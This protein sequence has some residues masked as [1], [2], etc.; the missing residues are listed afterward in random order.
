MRD[1]AHLGV[2]EP[3]LVGW[4]PLEARPD[5]HRDELGHLLLDAVHR[6]GR[7]GQQGRHAVEGALQQLQHRAVAGVER[8]HRDVR[9]GPRR[10]VGDPR[11]HRHRAH[12]GPVD[13]DRFARRTG[14][15]RVSRCVA[16]PEQQLLE[17]EVVRDLVL[18]G[19]EHV[20]VAV[21]DRRVVQALTLL[22]DLR[23]GEPG[24]GEVGHR[25][26][27]S[28]A[29]VVVLGRDLAA[30]VAAEQRV[31]AQLGG[32]RRQPLTDRGVELADRRVPL[33]LG[34]GVGRARLLDRHE[35]L[36]RSPRERPQRQLD[37]QVRVRQVGRVPGQQGGRVEHRPPAH[38]VEQVRRQR[39][40]QHLL[41]HH[42]QQHV[43]GGRVALRFQ[44]VQRAQ[45]GRQGRVLQLYRRLQVVAQRG[46]RVDRHGSSLQVATDICNSVIA[47]GSRSVRAAPPGGWSP[48]HPPACRSR[49]ARRCAAPACAARRRAP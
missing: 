18:L 11:V 21:E 26:D 17:A 49:R 44:G 43:G 46:R 8:L 31:L 48:R 35:A 13:G 33:V 25:D 9:F 22:D 16:A 15:G 24:R 7:D 42:A 20:L 30:R 3:A 2:G 14:R 39:Q 47:P 38:R 6:A 28:G 5:A 4:H 1:D 34:G 32:Q 23:H 37:R 12:R 10:D 41:Q 27:L 45:V 19:V 36:D 29:A 40:V